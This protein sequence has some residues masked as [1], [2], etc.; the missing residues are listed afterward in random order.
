MQNL[1]AIKFE[2]D[3]R[4]S[5]HLSIMWCWS[6]MWQNVKQFK[7]YKYIERHL[8]LFQCLILYIRL[9]KSGK[10]FSWN[11]ALGWKMINTKRM[12]LRS[13]FCLYFFK[14]KSMYSIFTLL[15]AP[16]IPGIIIDLQGRLYLLTTFV[17]ATDMWVFTFHVTSF[18]ITLKMKRFQKL[19]YFVSQLFFDLINISLLE[20]NRFSA[21]S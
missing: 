7:N 14:L 4:L 2:N 16:V 17:P 3:A 21:H 15:S 19:L 20:T 13:R 10:R 18:F 12:S 6:V 8:K 9:Y 1:N 5:S 11:L